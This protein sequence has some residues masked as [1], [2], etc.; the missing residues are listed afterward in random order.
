MSKTLILSD[1]E[2]ENLHFAR[3]PKY[4]ETPCSV[5]CREQEQGGDKQ[6]ACTGGGE[7]YTTTGGPKETHKLGGKTRGEKETHKQGG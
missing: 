5:Q 4:C 6:D 2:V 3:W 7:L 1:S